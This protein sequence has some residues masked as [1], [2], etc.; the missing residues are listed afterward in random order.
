[1]RS[2]ALLLIKI[3]QKLISKFTPR[4]CRYYPTCSE[5]AVWLFKNTDFCSAFLATFARILRCNQLFKGGIDY[6]IVRKNF[7]TIFAFKK[8]KISPISFWFVRQNGNK[9]YVIKKI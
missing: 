4:S 5:Y 7:S 3:Y 2:F 9:F 8:I 6:P 1:M